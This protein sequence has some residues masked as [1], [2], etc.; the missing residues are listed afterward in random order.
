MEEEH[1]DRGRK[2][3]RFS[4]SGRALAL[5][6]IVIVSSACFALGFFVGRAAAPE[7]E[8]VVLK[9][10]KVE[11]PVPAEC[12]EPAPVS[13]PEVIEEQVL[14]RTAPKPPPPKRRKVEKPKVVE[15]PKEPE[16]P[17]PKAVPEHYSVQVGA[18]G[19]LLDAEKLSK[20]FQAKGYEAFVLREG[21]PGTEAVFKV[22]VGEF[23][24]L[25]VA[26]LL[27]VKIKSI[28][29]IGAFVVQVE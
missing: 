22:R 28:E 3:Y 26:R 2:K 24:D 25:D 6:I 29:G 23:K 13:R 19:N 17:A 5:I 7:R 10:V 12:P 4:L 18:Y 16:K 1:A 9:K 8:K 27:A 15:K 11:V 20:E 21:E 14:I